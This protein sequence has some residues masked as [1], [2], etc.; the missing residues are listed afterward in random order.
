MGIRT[1]M[2]RECVESLGRTTLQGVKTSEYI[3]KDVVKVHTVEISNESAGKILG[4]ALGKYVSI[5]CIYDY[6]ENKEILYDCVAHHIKKAVGDI[7]K[8]DN[9]LVVGLGNANIT[10]DALGPYVC[11]KVFVSRHIKKYL[12]ELID[13][14]TKNVCAVKT[15]VLANTGIETAEII[16]GVCE[17][18]KPQLIIVVDALAAADMERIGTSV[19]I[20]DTGISPG[21][22]V[23]NKRSAITYEETGIP[24]ISIGVPTVVYAATVVENL[25]ENLTVNESI[26]KDDFEKIVGMLQNID[27]GDCVV[28]PKNIDEIIIKMSS[29]LAQCINRAVHTN[30]SQK[31]IEYFMN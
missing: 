12:P 7:E 24:V 10:P 26:S 22:G 31:E 28:T 15:G 2:A 14:R 19:Q 8:I 23:G 16:K 5:D 30:L 17:K 1:D 25:M 3:F 6:E 29:L 20:S 21:S 13:S 9:I 27:G 4:K 11:D 18:V